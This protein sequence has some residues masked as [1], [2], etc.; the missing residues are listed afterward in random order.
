M[1]NN[2]DFLEPVKYYDYFL[3]E[4]FDE[5]AKKY[6]NRLVDESGIDIEENQRIVEKY[7]EYNNI[8]GDL[9]KKL[10]NLKILKFVAIA[11]EIIFGFSL[12]GSL[13]SGISI[14]LVFLIALT[15]AA[16]YAHFGVLNKKIKNLNE[17]LE[18]NEGYLNKL[19]NEAYDTMAN[20]NALFT[21]EMT[22]DMIKNLVPILNIDD[23]FDIKRFA[24]LVENY[25]FSESMNNDYSTLNLVSGDIIGNPFVFI[26][27][28]VHETILYTYEGSRTISYE[29]AYIDSD[30]YRRV[31][32]VTETLHASVE[33]EGPNYFNQILL[34]YG[35]EAA[36]NLKFSR[37]PKSKSMTSNF[38]NKVFQSDKKKL[39]KLE[40]E[41]VMKGGSFQSMANEEFDINFAAYD[42]DNEAEFRL[43]F[44]NLGQ[45]SM[46]DFLNN[47]VYGDDLYFYKENM[48][49]TLYC[50]HTDNWDI[51]NDASNYTHFDFVS[52]RNNFMN[53]NKKYFQDMFFTFAPL[54]SIPIYQQ[55]KSQEYI[56]GDTFKYKYNR[57]TTEMIANK[58]NILNLRPELSATKTI[59]KTSPI[60][61]T[62]DT[63]L[64]QVDA[65]SYRTEQRVD[66]KHVTAGNGY[67]YPVEVPWTLYIPIYKTSTMEVTG[68]DID[69][70]VYN[71]Y[72]YN[73]N[74]KNDMQNMAYDYVYKDK[75]FGAITNRNDIALSD[76][77]KKII[78][79]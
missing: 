63:D 59:L 51:D 8:K 45:R 42:R 77:I 69:E 12:F 23:N 7:K 29:E 21:S 79:K 70:K 39:K 75:L 48:I 76:R 32:T 6:F 1:E 16:A 28:L 11:F 41:S 73:N 71:R 74:F 40:R 18:D 52:C 26:K 54:L 44:T 43:L 53:L 55:Q 19:K 49:N 60:K 2:L 30:G 35:N 46:M 3:K 68:I 37:E 56:Y 62:G 5:D 66:I 72:K 4:K 38:M 14:G 61:T 36:P 9:G 57:Y 67:S 17:I 58:M 78:K 64:V 10:R 34:V 50:T 22:T 15:G 27:H 65:Y 20:L 31:R 47:T 24:Q 33:K 13:S 25:G